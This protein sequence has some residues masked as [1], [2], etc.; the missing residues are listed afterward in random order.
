MLKKSIAKIL[1]KNIRK[2]DDEKFRPVI[3]KLVVSFDV[4]NFVNDIYVSDELKVKEEDIIDIL[5]S[6]ADNP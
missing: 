6:F 4:A 2:F 3:T 1:E 5:Q